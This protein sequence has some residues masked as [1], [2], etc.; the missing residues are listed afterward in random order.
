MV[1]LSFADVKEMKDFQAV[2]DNKIAAKRKRQIG[3]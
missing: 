2:L 1:G 3:K